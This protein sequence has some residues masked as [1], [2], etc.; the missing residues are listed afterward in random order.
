METGDNN[1]EWIITDLQNDLDE[2]QRRIKD[3]GLGP[4]DQVT[5][6]QLVADLLEVILK[7]MPQQLRI[8]DQQE[9]EVLKL[10]DQILSLGEDSDFFIAVAM[11]QNMSDKIKSNSN[12]LARSKAVIERFTPDE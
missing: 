10:N 6:N 3:L 5:D 9:A 11:L 7:I 12:M 1:S 2:V 8:L 4:Q